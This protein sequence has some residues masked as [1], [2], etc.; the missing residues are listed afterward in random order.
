MP[1]NGFSLVELLIALALSLTT[2]L[3]MMMLFKQVGRVGISVTQDA[4]FDLQLET[5]ILI[6]QKLVQGAGYG[7]GHFKDIKIGSYAERPAVFWR[8]RPDLDKQEMTCQ[9]VA[10]AVEHDEDIFVHRLLLLSSSS[11]SE[12][13]DL[14]SLNWDIDNVLAKM[15]REHEESIFSYELIDYEPINYEPVSSESVSSESVSSESTDSES[16]DSE[17]T[18]TE[19]VDYESKGECNPFGIKEIK[20]SRK[21]II[22]GKKKNITEGLGRFVQRAVCLNNITTM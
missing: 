19:P 9:G 16:T 21:I 5:G 3:M 10:Q 13:A 18:D 17:Q 7:T 4:E 22:T 11:C 2:I 14:E 15:H 20:G 8:L 12:T 1:K 6:T